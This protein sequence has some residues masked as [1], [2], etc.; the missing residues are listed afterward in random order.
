MAFDEVS[1][2]MAEVADQPEESQGAE[3]QETA[4]PADGDVERDYEKDSAYAELRRRA[5]AAEA[6]AK[7][8]EDSA[9]EQIESAFTEKKDAE[10]DYIRRFGEEQGLSASEIEELISERTEDLETE[11]ENEML[12]AELEKLRARNSEIEMQELINSDLAEVQ[13]INPEIKSIDELGETFAKMVNVIDE[14]GN[15]ILTPQQAYYAAMASDGRDAELKPK[16]PEPP[17]MVSAGKQEKTFF[18]RAE[19]EAMTPSEVNENLDLIQK[20]MARWK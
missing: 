8:L 14:D 7:E 9:R 5:E 2:N 18:T 12:R 17:G 20:S 11:H 13:K 6:R 10:L 4:E 16:A 19:V 1:E 3:E 15:R